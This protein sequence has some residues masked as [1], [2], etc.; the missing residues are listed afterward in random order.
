MKIINGDLFDNYFDAIFHQCNCFHTMGGG[1]A[2]VLSNKFPIVINADRS[3]PYG[4][5]EKL[6]TFS[7]AFIMSETSFNRKI[8]YNLYSQFF[9]GKGKVQTDYDALKKS[10]KN[11]C[12]DLMQVFSNKLE[13]ENYNIQLAIPYLI[14]CGLAGGDETTVINLID[15]IMDKYPRINLTAYK[16]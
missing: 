10:F 15:N 13:N 8:V 9:Y 3:T 6:G 14:G 4:S 1:F 12:D 16:K 2:K 5:H 11:A 7:K